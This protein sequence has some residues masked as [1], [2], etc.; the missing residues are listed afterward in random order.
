MTL[1]GF[2]AHAQSTM[3]TWKDERGEVYGSIYDFLHWLGLDDDRQN[4]WHNWLAAEF[5]ST[6]HLPESGS[7]GSI[8]ITLPGESKP[9]PMTNFAGFRTLVILS[10]RKSKI[11]REFADKA[12]ELFG[13]AV[14]G[15]QRLHAEIDA[16]AAAAPREGREFV[17]GETE[18]ARQDLKRAR[19]DEGMMLRIQGTVEA[20]MK[21]VSQEMLRTH[22]S[23]MRE[24]VRVEIRENHVWSFSKRSRNHCE[25]MK[26]GQIL[27]GDELRHLDEAE[28]IVRVVDF[29]KDRIDPAVWRRHGR[30]FKNIYAVELKRVKMCESRDEGLPPPVAFNQ[31]EYHIVYTEADYD[32]MVQTLAD[33]QGRFDQIAGNDA[34]LFL[35]PRRGQKSI[36]DS[37]R[38]HD[39]GRGSESDATPQGNSLYVR[40]ILC[41]D[42]D[43]QFQPSEADLIDEIHIQGDETL[44]T[45][46][47]RLIAT[48]GID[49]AALDQMTVRSLAVE[50]DG[51]KK[52]FIMKEAQVDE[53][54]KN[55]TEVILMRKGG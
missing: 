11:A 21:S 13:G 47:A 52:K 46:L 14:V 18:A 35:E 39:N 9:T 24:M 41:V 30:K 32:L 37:M 50:E 34:R 3:R 51:K 44:K 49:S 12:L 43:G 1:P 38:K 29:L 19:E 27:H 54:S 8:W 23:S 17:L 5:Q 22:I 28:H 55:Y 4:D 15:D 53:P 31:A 42:K 20:V 16:N 45:T 6:C 7:G 10:L 2:E 48:L 36:I 25:L 33:C 40:R 26:A